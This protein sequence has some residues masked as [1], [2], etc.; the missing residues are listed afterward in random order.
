MKQCTKCLELK[1][2]DNFSKFRNGLR[3]TCK[4]CRRI[5]SREYRV[6]NR[7]YTLE[8]SR[9]HYKNNKEAHIQRCYDWQKRNPDRVK[10]ITKKYRDKNHGAVLSRNAKRRAD[11]KNATPSWADIERI[12]GLYKLATYLSRKYG[13]KIHVDHIVPLNGN[14]VC[15]LHTLSNLQLLKAE[16][17]LRKSNAWE[18]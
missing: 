16:D 2:F 1:S 11:K 15:G 12:K 13:I 6:K 4:A 9:E 14:N 8:Y 7:E 10:S 18:V 17:N 3:P 5:E